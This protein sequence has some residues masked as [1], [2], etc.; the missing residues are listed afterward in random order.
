MRDHPGSTE[1]D[2]LCYLEGLLDK[3]LKELNWEY[4]KADNQVPVI[5]KHYAY[6]ITRGVLLLY[7]ERDGFS[8][9]ANETKNHI[10]NTMIEPVR[11]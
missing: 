9:S 2:A 10:I 7:K 11:Q 3:V 6:E 4:L 5:S 1:E 8:Q